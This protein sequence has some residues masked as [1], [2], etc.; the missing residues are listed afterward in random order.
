[1]SDKG[2]LVMFWTPCIYEPDQGISILN[3]KC[4]WPISKGSEMH[5]LEHP[6]RHPNAPFPIW[7]STLHG[8]YNHVAL[9]AWIKAKNLNKVWKIIKKEFRV[10]EIIGQRR[11]DH[12]DD[13]RFPLN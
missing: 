12:F 4:S 10:C 11:Q 6:H 7:T 1:M 2:W 8:S 5:F 13:E 3:C 9:M